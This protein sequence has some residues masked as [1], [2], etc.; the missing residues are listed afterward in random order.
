MVEFTYQVA[1]DTIRTVGILVGIIYYL[2]ILRNTQKTRELTLQSQELTLKAQKQA[3]ETRQAQLLSTFSGILLTND[4]LYNSMMYWSQQPKFEYED[5]K[6]QHSFGSDSNSSL[7]RLLSFYELIGVLSRWELVDAELVDDLF[8]LQ[9]DRFR[10]IVK[11]IQ[12][13]FGGTG[14]YENYEWLGE[15]RKGIPIRRSL[16][17]KT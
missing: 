4:S 10:P 2:A 11:G 8:V 12:E 5:F 1:L 7:L 14:Y 13:D 16:H 6:V 3:L 9:W 17:K 15:S